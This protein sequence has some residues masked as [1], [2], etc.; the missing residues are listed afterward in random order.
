MTEE[1]QRVNPR[2][3]RG[4]RPRRHHQHLTS[5]TGNVH[6][7]RQISTVITLM[8]ISTSNSEF[9]DLFARAFA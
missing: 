4:N 7:D 8:R 5:D 1:L 2:N 9:E 3:E 6:L